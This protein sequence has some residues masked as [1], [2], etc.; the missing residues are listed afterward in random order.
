[1]SVS[2]TILS[3]KNWKLNKYKHLKISCESLLY[4]YTLYFIIT[5]ILGKFRIELLALL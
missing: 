3:P 5:S 2:I 1:M 4:L